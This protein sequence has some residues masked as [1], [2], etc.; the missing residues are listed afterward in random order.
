ML[1]FLK[2]LFGMDKETAEAAGVQIEQVPYKIEPPVEATVTPIVEKVEVKEV[3]VEEKKPAAMTAK[4]KP[5]G[6]K[7][8]Q[9][10]KPAAK[11][12]TP[13][14]AAKPKQPVRRGRKPK[15]N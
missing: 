12:T 10:P 13:K 11:P 2:K 14:P 15:A 5:R 8:P 3:A 6:P 4:K 1:G 7:K 9:G